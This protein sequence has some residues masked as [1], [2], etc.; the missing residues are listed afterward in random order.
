MSIKKNSYNSAHLL[1]M[2]FVCEGEAETPEQIAAKAA[3]AADLQA[4]IDAAVA[5]QVKG[6]KDK[7]AELLGKMKA[8][9]GLDPAELRTLKERLDA[10]DDAKLLAEGKKN[11]VIE[12]YTE[13]MRAQHALD[14]KAKD[15][16]VKNEAK[17][18]DT[19][20]G[21]V[22]DNQILKATKDLHKGA[23]EDAL[24]HARNIFTLDAKGNAVKLDSEGRPELGKDGS[25][26]FGPLEWIEQQ[27][28]LK[29]HWFPMDTSGGSSSQTR[30]GGSGTGKSISRANFDKLSPLEQ[31]KVARS[32]TKITD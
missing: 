9:D 12:K 29:P 4:K 6:L 24:L 32:G 18:A 31:G 26:P 19:Y 2:L 21:A 13:R 8:F 28:E 22:L 27:K 17:R 14:L 7:N 10:D 25:T 5:I 3:S 30:D 1:S 11:V 15:E 16:L 23:V 20:K